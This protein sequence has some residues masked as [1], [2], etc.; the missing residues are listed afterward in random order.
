MNNLIGAKS[1]NT[2][3]RGFSAAEPESAMVAS[4]GARAM[5]KSGIKS[6]A[7]DQTATLN[8]LQRRRFRPLN[9]AARPGAISQ[10]TDLHHGSDY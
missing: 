5:E 1:G 7:C 4:W 9:G 10:K 3:C 2:G 6:A 8:L